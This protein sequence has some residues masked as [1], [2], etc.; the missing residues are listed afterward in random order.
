MIHCILWCLTILLYES[1][2]MSHNN[3]PFFVKLQN[4][5]SCSP[6][7][8]SSSVE[9]YLLVM[10][11]RFSDQGYPVFEPALASG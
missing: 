4:I 10:V 6:P 9:I 11:A 1:Y 3:E 8:R 5:F 7:K 2:L